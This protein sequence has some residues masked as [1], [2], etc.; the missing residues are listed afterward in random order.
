MKKE[1]KPSSSGKGQL[2]PWA[3]LIL[4]IL[5]AIVSLYCIARVGLG[6]VLLK[7]IFSPMP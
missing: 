1:G 3:N 6:P 7:A 2:P 4:M 5:A